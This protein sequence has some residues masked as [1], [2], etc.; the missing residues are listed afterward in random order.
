MLR[1]KY[2]IEAD[3]LSKNPVLEAS[4]DT[5]KRLKIVNMI[6]LIDIVTDKSIIFTIKRIRNMKKQF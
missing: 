5:E 2:N 6:K 1:G 3:C 4:E